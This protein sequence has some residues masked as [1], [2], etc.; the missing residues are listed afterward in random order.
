MPQIIHWAEALS[1]LVK[2]RSSVYIKWYVVWGQVKYDQPDCTASCLNILQN[3]FQCGLKGCSPFIS[4]FSL[5]KYFVP[6][7]DLSKTEMMQL[8]R[9][10]GKAHL[11]WFPLISVI[12]EHK[13]CSETRKGVIYSSAPR[14]GHCRTDVGHK[15]TSILKTDNGRAGPLYG[16]CFHPQKNKNE[17]TNRN[18]EGFLP[19]MALTE[20]KKTVVCG[21][22]LA[23]VQR[24]QWPP[25]EPRWTHK[26]SHLSQGVHTTAQSPLHSWASATA[27]LWPGDCRRQ[28]G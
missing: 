14:K 10:V 17:W 6:C 20:Y 5:W 13:K 26:L 12:Y 7:K 19:H 15:S 23:H 18:P 16:D 28:S 1:I 11:S 3:G 24:S 27:F 8:Q 4:C 2:C 25:A 22:T 21:P 9:F